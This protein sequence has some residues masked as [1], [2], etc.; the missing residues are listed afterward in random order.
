MSFSTTQ[1]TQSTSSGRKQ[2][3]SG[4]LQSG[5][6]KKPSTV[7]I[8]QDPLV[9]HGC[10]VGRA[11]H[12]FCNVQTLITNGLHAMSDDAPEDE[13]LP[14]VECKEHAVF[15][16]LLQSVPGLE[17]QLMLS[18]EEEVIAMAN[19]KGT[20]STKADDTKGMKGL[21]IDWIT[22]KGQSL[23]PHI[24]HNVKSGHGFNHICTGALLCPV[25]CCSHAFF[26][27]V[28]SRT[29]T[30]LTNGKIQVA[31]D[32]WPMFFLLHSGL[33]IL[34]FKHTFMLPS[35]VDQ[36]PKV[37]HSGNACIQ[38]MCW[39]MKASLAYVATQAC[40]ALT[41]AQVFSHTNLMT[42]SKHFYNS[43]LELL[44]DSDE[45]GEVD[46]LMAWWNHQVFP[47]YSD[48]E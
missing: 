37:T 43:I 39:M 41:S 19:L 4:I 21:I 48:I 30:K 11:V 22:P 32:Q 24:H 47:L 26:M 9:H 12:A 25:V 38:S 8:S 14:A 7:L 40:F 33:L 2:A 17:D 28:A 31:R 10:H 6:R 3:S 36:E 13:T 27:H 44:N 16:E 18:S 1:D 35:S 29:H 20:N 5:P 15:W 46:Q 42:D 23:I 45:K 34:V